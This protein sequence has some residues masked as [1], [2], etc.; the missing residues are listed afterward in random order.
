MTALILVRHG[1]SLANE[2]QQIISKPE[3][4]LLPE[5]GLCETGRQQVHQTAAA[6]VRWA[7]ERRQRKADARSTQLYIYAS[8]FSRT[9]ETAVLLAA[10]VQALDKAVRA[11]DVTA[12]PLLRERDFGI[13]DETST[14]NYDIVWGRD[15]QATEEARA[16]NDR[17]QVERPDHV[18]QRAWRCFQQAQEQLRNDAAV[19]ADVVDRVVV[20]VAHGDTCQMIQTRLV[21]A[22]AE[23][24]RTAVQHLDTAGWRAFEVDDSV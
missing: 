10:S 23:L 13:Y 17:D 2:R 14:D 3:L 21:G 9:R 11:G 1:K 20:L 18:Q 12:T 24:H 15:S 5:N 16:L 4:G 19:A 7:A 8:D 6:I 22:P